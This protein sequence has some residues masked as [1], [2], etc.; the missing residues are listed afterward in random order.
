MSK[1]DNLPLIERLR[2]ISE[3]DGTSTDHYNVMQESADRLDALEAVYKAARRL[4]RT[5]ATVHGLPGLS[6]EDAGL[7]VN[8]MWIDLRNALKRLGN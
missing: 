6:N 2:F 1:T 8:A 7:T 5:I 4:D 3:R